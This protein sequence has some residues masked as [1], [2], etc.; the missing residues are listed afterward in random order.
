MGPNDGPFLIFIISIVCMTAVLRATKRDVATPVD[1]LRA[2]GQVPGVLYGHGIDN[3]ILVVSA[4]DLTKMYREAGES[5][6]VDLIVGEAA[7]VKVLIHDIQHNVLTNDPQHVDFYQVNMTEKITA[8]ISIVVI[9]ES[10]AVKAM[11]GTLV[12][13]LESIEVK[14]L[15]TDLVK[16]ITIDVSALATFDDRITVAELPVP[17]G[18]EV[19]TDAHLTVATV[20]APRAEEPESTPAAESEAA[21]GEAAKAEGEAAAGEAAKAEESAKE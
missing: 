20:A 18:M 8:E 16:E 2:K 5:T 1:Q 9:G 10:P 4:H 3:Q 13:G 7:P 21:A 14:C 15:P 19:L 11:G 12:T 17:A 6:L